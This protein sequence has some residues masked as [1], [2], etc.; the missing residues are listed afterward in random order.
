MPEQMA[1]SAAQSHFEVLADFLQKFPGVLPDWLVS[2]DR[3]RYGTAC[4]RGAPDMLVPCI[5]DQMVDPQLG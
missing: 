1:L 2:G 5:F 4:V 3:C